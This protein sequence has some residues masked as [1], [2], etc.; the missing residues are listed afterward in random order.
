[1]TAQELI[2]ASL[3]LINGQAYAPT[4]TDG[5][6]TSALGFLNMML[7]DWHTKNLTVPV[8]TQENLTLVASQASYTI[9]ASGAN[10]LTARPLSVSPATFLRNSGTDYP[11][12]IIGEGEYNGIAVKTV[13]SI[14]QKLFYKNNYP[15]GIIYLFPVPAEAY[16]LVLNSIKELTDLAALSTT[17]DLPSVYRRAV[18]Y[19]FAVELAPQYFAQIDG[20]VAKTADDMYRTVSALNRED[21]ISDVNDVILTRAGRFNIYT[22]E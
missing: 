4:D 11:L 2:T 10:F 22:G 12:D 15:L 1:M 20:S 21:S 8:M 7:G 9:G 5:E 3:K 14:P 6:L 17:V 13:T 18:I 19:N 16:T